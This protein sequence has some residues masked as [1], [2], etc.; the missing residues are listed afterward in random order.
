MHVSSAILSKP[1]TL[2]ILPGCCLISFASDT[3]LLELMCF[4]LNVLRVRMYKAHRVVFICEFSKRIPDE[5]AH[6]LALEGGMGERFSATFTNGASQQLR[7]D[8]AAA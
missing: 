8:P 2:D 4:K 6:E 7:F 5:L 3:I 1:S